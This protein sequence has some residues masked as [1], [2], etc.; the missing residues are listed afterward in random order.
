MTVNDYVLALIEE[1]SSINGSSKIAWKNH[2][3]HFVSIII[4][5]KIDTDHLA[6]Y[7][8]KATTGPYF[9]YSTVYSLIS[10]SDVVAVLHIADVKRGHFLRFP[11]DSNFC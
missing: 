11:I 9:M 1:A 5:N 10:K 2:V 7:F 6:K 4:Y 8:R 3:K